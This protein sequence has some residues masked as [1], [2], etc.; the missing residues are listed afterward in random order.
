MT[1]IEKLSNFSIDVQAFRE[2][3]PHELNAWWIDHAVAEVKRLMKSFVLIEGRGQHATISVVY[4]KKLIPTQHKLHDIIFT[5]IVK[6][7]N[8]VKWLSDKKVSRSQWMWDRN[9]AR[10]VA[11]KAVMHVYAATVAEQIAGAAYAAENP[12]E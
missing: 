6:A 9:E 12:S 2:E 8:R 3:Y 4:E 10:P 1:N 11:I 7:G 5:A